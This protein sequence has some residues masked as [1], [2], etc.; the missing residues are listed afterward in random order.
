MIYII[1]HTITRG[2]L[3]FGNSGRR[4]LQRFHGQSSV[5]GTQR[6][7]R[8]GVYRETA[9]AGGRGAFARLRYDGDGDCIGGRV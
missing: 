2:N 5:P 3:S 7:R 9:D 1:V 4:P 6:R 8:F